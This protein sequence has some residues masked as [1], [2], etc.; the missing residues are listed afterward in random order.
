M[1]HCA[2]SDPKLIGMAAIAALA[3]PGTARVAVGTDVQGRRGQGR[4]EEGDPATSPGMLLNAQ[5]GH[6]EPVAVK[7]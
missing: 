2:R 6:W 1:K 4:V 5:L 7:A 3:P